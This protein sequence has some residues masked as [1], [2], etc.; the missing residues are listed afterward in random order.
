MFDFL[1]GLTSERFGLKNETRKIENSDSFNW[2]GKDDNGRTGYINITNPFQGILVIGG[3]GAGK[4]Y[5]V[6]EPITD[7]A[8]GKGYTGLLYDFKF[9]VL[10]KE[11][12]KAFI[13]HG[14]KD[15]KLWIVN[16]RDMERT[17]RV[18][19]IHPDNMPV[20]AFANE[21][22]LA[23]LKNLKKDWIQKQDFWADNAIAFLK[24]I[25]WFLKKNEPQI[26]TLPH[27][28]S[29]ALSEY[30]KVLN[31]LAQDQECNGMIRSL[32]TAHELEAESQVAGVVSSLQ[33]PIDKLNTP[34][35]FW[36]LSGNDFSLDLN[37]PEDPSVLCI[38]NDP[39]LQDTFS[40]VISLIATVVMKKINQQKK[41]RSF[42]MLDEAPTIFIPNLH[43]LPATARSNKVATIYMAQDLSQMEMMYGKEQARV[44][45]ANLGNQFYGMVNDSTT[46]EHASKIFGKAE[47]KVETTSSSTSSGKSSSSSKSKSYSFQEKELVP[48]SEIMNLPL[49][50]FVGKVTGS[51]N[52]LFKL[53]PHIEKDHS[54]YAFEPF[55]IFPT[56]AGDRDSDI[57]IVLQDNYRKIK[58][59]VKEMLER[60]YVEPEK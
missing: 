51:K 35:I 28:V 18:N 58:N 27:A 2:K 40:P 6:A 59:E 23:V 53:K 29:L 4:S 55:Y 48:A 39:E 24:A 42:F 20:S 38:G 21:Y 9:P 19:P 50:K 37:N 15:R 25:I 57:Q 30:P 8:V 36:V 41:R 5:T 31:V 34:E 16:F 17:H 46:A 52:P 60:R 3:A 33:T 45:I 49:G 43:N 10:T 22:T 11:M 32:I 12:H 13:N 7:Q 14:V 47:K 1:G 44:L 54:E 56:I 26:C